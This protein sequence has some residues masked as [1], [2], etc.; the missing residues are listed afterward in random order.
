MASRPQAS[1]TDP[2]KKTKKKRPGWEFPEGSGIRIYKRKNDGAGDSVS[3]LVIVPNSVSRTGRIKKAFKTWD[4]A[5]KFA[6]DQKLGFEDHGKAFSSLPPDVQ[7]D[8]IAAWAELSKLNLSLRDAVKAGIRQLRPLGGIKTVSEVADLLAADK[9][10]LFDS[11]DLREQSHASFKTRL[12]LI[13]ARLGSKNINEVTW[14]DVEAWTDSLRES[15]IRGRPLQP[16]AVN[17][18]VRA[19]GELFNYAMSQDLCT[20]NP[21]SKAPPSKRG[22]LGRASTPEKKGRT[23]SIDETRRLLFA[24]LDHQD[25]GLLPSVVLRVFCGIRTNEACRLRWSDVRMYEKRPIILMS[26]DETKTGEPR[27]APLPEVA[28]K[29]LELCKN[30][31]GFVVPDLAL[32]VG[33]EQTEAVPVRDYCD[34]FNQLL[35][36][37]GFKEKVKVTKDRNGRKHT[38]KRFDWDAN[39]TRRTFASYHYERDRDPIKTAY[40]LGHACT[41][42]DRTLFKHYLTRLKGEEGI[43][44]QYF[45]ITPAH[46]PQAG[47]VIELGKAGAA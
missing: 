30:R 7:R 25:L 28:I 36:H 37:A 24:A 1:V 9:Q 44:E 13:R 45:A 23:L 33:V 35:K 38:R 21:I 41:N 17:N 19:L 27:E 22:F 10:L 6:S 11:G 12:V 34:D 2:T 5:C 20:S 46:R 3:F 16:K 29:W 39:C 32:P 8:A 40:A 42:Q 26:Y 14:Q 47:E 4:A 18:Q 31:T 43:G 15:G